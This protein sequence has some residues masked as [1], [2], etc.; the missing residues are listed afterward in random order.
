MPFIEIKLFEFRAW[1]VAGGFSPKR[2]DRGG[3]ATS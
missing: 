2:W 1:A 3:G